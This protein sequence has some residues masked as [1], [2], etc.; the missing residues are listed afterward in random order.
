MGP[1]HR[2]KPARGLPGPHGR[3]AAY[4][5]QAKSGK[6]INI[7]S[8]NALHAVANL[9]AYSASKAAVISFTQAMAIEWARYG[10]SVNA[11]APG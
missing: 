8:N 3:W 7:A 9:A 2:H 6:I 4:M 1:H 11:L 5:V 10:I